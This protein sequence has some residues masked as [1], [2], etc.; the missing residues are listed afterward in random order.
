MIGHPLPYPHPD[1]GDLC[2]ASVR[3]RNPDPGTAVATLAL[4]IEAPEGP[5]YPF[6][7]LVNIAA[8]ILSAPAQIEHDVADALSRA[9]IGIAATAAGAMHRQALRIE[10]IVVARTGP[11]GIERGMLEQ[12]N[13][14]VPGAGAD[15]CDPHFHRRHRGPLIDGGLA[16]PPLDSAGFRSHLKAHAA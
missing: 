12:P 5:D 3:S 16:D 14:L 10:K 15:R 6:F 13:E 1:R 7:E 11:G 9:V 2:L 8:H 4:H